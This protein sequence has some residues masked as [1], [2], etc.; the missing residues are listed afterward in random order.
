MPFPSQESAFYEKKILVQASKFNLLNVLF[1][2]DYFDDAIIMNHTKHKDELDKEKAGRSERLWLSISEAC[3]DSTNDEEF[4]EFAFIEDEQIAQFA[5][6]FDLS[7]YLKLDWVKASHWFKE[8]V[9][10]YDVVMI[11]FTKSGSRLPTF[12]D[13][14]RNKAAT[15]YYRLYI[16]SRSLTPTSRLES[17]LVKESSVH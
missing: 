10:D 6:Q 15:F 9:T 11:L 1:S 13:Y 14:C 3:N 8:M 12:Y 7:K 5:S 2:D 17:F 4:G 16:K